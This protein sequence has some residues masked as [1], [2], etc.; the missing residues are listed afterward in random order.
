M[1]R[2]RYSATWSSRSASSN[3]SR[4]RNLRLGTRRPGAPPEGGSEAMRNDALRQPRY[5]NAY[6]EQSSG[7]RLLG[8]LF[9][10]KAFPGGG[11]VERPE[12]FSAERSLRDVR[13]RQ[14]ELREL[15]AVRRVTIDAPAREKRL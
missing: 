7:E 14:G 10:G 13:H 6:A 2:S 1:K 8:P 3:Q 5:V 15:A 11:D 9:R 12:V 4:E